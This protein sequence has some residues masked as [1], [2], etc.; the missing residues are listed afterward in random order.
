M[1]IKHLV[2]IFIGLFSI[3]IVG[4][5]ISFIVKEYLEEILDQISKPETIQIIITFIIPGI[6]GICSAGFIIDRQRKKFERTKRAI[7]P[8]KKV[9]KEVVKEVIDRD[10]VENFWMQIVIFVIVAG[11]LFS[12]IWTLII[13]IIG[14]IVLNMLQLI[15]MLILLL[16]SIF[17]LYGYYTWLKK[18]QNKE[19]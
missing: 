1:K 12:S 11:F 3:V 7:K 8:E 9:I 19:V 15:I 5:I 4:F 10:S 2:Y 16:G 17:F 18:R 13:Y 14:M 6:L